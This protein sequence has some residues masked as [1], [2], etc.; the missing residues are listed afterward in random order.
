VVSLKESDD[1]FVYSFTD[2]RDIP[3]ENVERFIN[4]I[5]NLFENV[6]S[7][8]FDPTNREFSIK[9]KSSPSKEYLE[10]VFHHFK[11]NKYTLN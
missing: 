11:V 10:S 4:R 3:E 6:D 2:Q 1:K 5:N 8:S 9:F 7:V